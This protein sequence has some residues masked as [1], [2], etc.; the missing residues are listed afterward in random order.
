MATNDFISSYEDEF[1]G[2]D[3]FNLDLDMNKSVTDYGV[4]GQT[5]FTDGSGK[6]KWGGIPYNL[7]LNDNFTES[8]VNT[9]RF[10]KIGAP[11]TTGGRLILVDTG[12]TGIHQ[13]LI[14]NEVKQIKAETNFYFVPN[15]QANYCM[16]FGFISPT[17]DT[18]I[19]LY[20]DLTNSSQEHFWFSCWNEGD[21]TKNEIYIEAETS[22]DISIVAS[23]GLARFYK[24]G[25][26]TS[27][28][29][30]NIPKD[31]ILKVYAN[32]NNGNELDLDY[33]KVKVLMDLDVF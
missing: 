25:V 27:T 12:V 21:I 19:W 9:E 31:K 2:L 13:D 20:Q 23:A 17:A 24:N 6:V 4:E 33:I 14:I 11:F 5:L 22:N 28:I 7:I 3:F 16:V 30:T 15:T 8:A 18:Y 26:L 10:T 29:K 32:T 1:I